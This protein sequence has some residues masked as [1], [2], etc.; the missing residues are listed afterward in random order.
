MIAIVTDTSAG[1]TKKEAQ[2][3]GIHVVPMTY[4]VSDHLYF[5]SFSDENG[6]FESL[7]FKN[8]Y[9]ATTSQVSSSAFLN[10]FEDL[11][12][13]NYEVIC[14]VISSR[15]SGTY[16][17]ACLAARELG[18]E[19]VAVIDSLLTVG[20]LRILTQKALHMAN[21]GLCLNEIVAKIE[22]EKTNDT[23][24]ISFTVDNMDALRRSGRLGIVKQSVGTILNLRPILV[25]KDGAIVFK[26]ISRGKSDQVRELVN[27]IPS[28]ATEVI[29]HY[30]EQTKN[31]EDLIKVIKNKFP[32]MIILTS[33]LGPV[34]SIHLG[35]SV[36]GISWAK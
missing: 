18:S 8:P 17:S 24:G 34:L 15:L 5:E 31:L 10:V 28:G 14:L 36:L 2:E 21:E 9:A 19:K 6:D 35:N 29:I 3:L 12:N 22:Q 13:K 27:T 7:I 25:L 23:I 16:S 26:S 33:K 1:F 11:V 32:D 4:N 20:A 30:L